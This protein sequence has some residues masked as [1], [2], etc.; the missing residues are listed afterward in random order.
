MIGMPNPFNVAGSPLNINVGSNSAYS[1]I[2]NPQ[3]GT[4][5]EILGGPGLQTGFAGFGGVI[6]LI[7]LAALLLR[8]LGGTKNISELVVNW[9]YVAVTATAGVALYKVI[10]LR[11]H[12]PFMTEI[13]HFV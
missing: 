9:L 8:V 6:V 10:F 4:G 13:A 2:P 11:W 1:S 3:V 5:A 7:V 12:V